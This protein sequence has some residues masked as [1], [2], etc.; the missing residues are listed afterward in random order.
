MP[1]AIM[2]PVSRVRGVAPRTRMAFPGPKD[3]GDRTDVIEYLETLS[4]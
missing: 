3:E 1:R 2:L 4:P